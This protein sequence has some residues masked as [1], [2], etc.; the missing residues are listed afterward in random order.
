MSENQEYLGA[1]DDTRSAEQKAK[2]FTFDEI[3]AS[4]A[5]VVWKEK[6]T[7]RKFPIFNQNGS[8]SCVAQTMAKL[9]GILYSEKFKEYVHFS[10]SHLYQRRSN[11]PQGGMI[12]TNVFDLARESVTLESLAPSQNMSDSQMDA[13]SVAP[14]KNEVGKLFKIGNYVTVPVKDIDTVASIIQQTNKGLM[15]WFYF[16]LAEWRKAVPEMLDV[17]MLKQG[18]LHHSVAAVDFLILSSAQTS[19]KRFWGKKA[20]VVEDTAWPETGRSGQRFITEDFFKKRNTFVGYPISFK[21]DD[22][23]PVETA[24]RFNFETDLKYNTEVSYASV[25]ALQKILRF[26]GLFPTNI[27]CTGIYGAV[28]AKAVV[29]YQ[30]K[31]GLIKAEQVAEFSGVNSAVGPRTRAHLNAKYNN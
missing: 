27:D 14:V 15:V 11:K 26:E 19:D 6:S 21:F 8:G 20:I 2:D 5:P 29:A 7:W 28:T 16:S 1:L 3:V 13:V 12:A 30:L 23:L 9:V 25:V 10:A 4:A 17:N 18:A 22:S 31:Y 24:P